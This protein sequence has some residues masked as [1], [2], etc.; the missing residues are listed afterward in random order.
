MFAGS[1]LATKTSTARS[2]LTKMGV[3]QGWAT[4]YKFVIVYLIEVH[5]KQPAA[6]DM[7]STCVYLSCPLTT[8][9]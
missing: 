1:C 8:A 9:S 2:Q 7:Y 6:T 5:D 4:T 3:V